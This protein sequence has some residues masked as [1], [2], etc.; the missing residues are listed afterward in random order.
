MQFADKLGT[1]KY[2]YLYAAKG[3]NPLALSQ[4][5]KS[6]SWY[7]GHRSC[8]LISLD[9]PSYF[10]YPHKITRAAALVF[11]GGS[12]LEMTCHLGIK[13]R[14]GVKQLVYQQKA[15]YIGFC[16]GAYLANNVEYT[17]DRFSHFLNCHLCLVDTSPLYGPAY[18]LNELP[19]VN[20]AKAV[21]LTL[22][23]SSDLFYVFWNGGGFYKNL[24][25]YLEKPLANYI[26]VYNGRGIAVME[27]WKEAPI[28]LCN[29]HPEIRFTQEEIENLFPQ[30][31]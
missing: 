6:F 28:I 20:T 7:L 31:K 22:N 17:K 24:D 29:V 11:P 30:F 10:Q 18:P 5:Q 14:E 16:A 3:A 25:E 1:D 27:F 21:P 4:T 19:S 12:A 2:I 13:G 26:D 15:S 8:Q 9:D 23:D